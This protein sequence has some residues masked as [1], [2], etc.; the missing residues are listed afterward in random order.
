MRKDEKS[1]SQRL[2]HSSASSPKNPRRYQGIRCRWNELV[3][4]RTVGLATV[5]SDTSLKIGSAIM[6]T[7]RRSLKSS[8]ISR[9]SL[10]DSKNEQIHDRY[11]VRRDEKAHGGSSRDLDSKAGSTLVTG[12]NT[13][14]L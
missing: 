5:A 14:E 4:E 13:H 9:V 11:S 6:S 3:E 8:A 1:F 7:Q 10:V 2:D 12:T